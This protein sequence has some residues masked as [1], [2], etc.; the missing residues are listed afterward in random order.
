MTDIE[1]M[2]AALALARRGLGEA[3]P[4]PS[5][6]CVIVREGVVVGRGRTGAGGRPH[7]ETAALA[8]AG[9]AARG[10]TVFVTLEPCSHHGQTPPC[11][12]ALVAAGVARVVIALRDPDARVNGRGAARLRDAGIAVTE[13]VC[14]QEAEAVNVGF[15]SVVRRGRPWV[16]L[17]LATSLDGRIATRTGAS[18]WITGE[19]SRRRAHAL[20]G[21]HDAVMVGVRTVLADD[22]ELTCRIDGFRSVPMI[23]VVVDSHLRTPLDARLARGAGDNP[24]WILHRDGADPMRAGVF[25]DL[26]ARLFEVAHSDAGVDLEAGLRALAEAGITRLLVEGGATL[27]AGLVRADLVDR[28]EWFAAPLVIGGDGL[29]AIAGF[30][31]AALDEALRFEPGAANASGRDVHMRYERD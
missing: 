5:V 31:V 24:L 11:A 25:R 27:A 29:P 9:E 23:R 10:A 13:G 26:G 16:T 17:K 15:L 4:N 18:Q 20:R 1:H 19:A 3:A 28:I 21:S 8:M 30:G 7:A 6:G 14:E 22:P 12:E 2:R